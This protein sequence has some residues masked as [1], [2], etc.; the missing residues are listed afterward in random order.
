MLLVHIIFACWIH[1][2][3]NASSSCNKILDATECSD[4]DYATYVNCIRNKRLK[5]S[6]CEFSSCEATSEDEKCETCSD[7]N[8]NYC[9]SNDCQP[10]CTQC[11]AETTCD[12]AICC[13]RTCHAQC[14][15]SK[16]RRRCKESCTETIT[17]KPIILPEKVIL[18]NITTVIT[19][20]TSV[21]NT[22]VIDIPV[23]LNS[24]TTNNTTVDENSS[25]VSY[26]ET[27]DIASN[28]CNVVGPQQCKPNFRWPFLQCL[29]PTTQQCGNFC[30]SDTV[31]MQP[32][33]SCRGPSG[34]D[35]RML[36][37]PQPR[38]QCAYHYSWPYVSCGMNHQQASCE[39]CYQH[40]ASGGFP[41]QDCSPFCYDEGYGIGPYY[42]QGPFFRRAF[43]YS[44][45][46]WFFGECFSNF[47]I[48]G[49]GAP[50]GD[51]YSPNHQDWGLAPFPAYFSANCS[52]ETPNNDVNGF[53]PSN[54]NDSFVQFRPFYG[55]AYYPGG[56]PFV[57]YPKKDIKI[58]IVVNRTTAKPTVKPESRAE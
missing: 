34:C 39:G 6:D 11:C 55:Q 58:E 22:N 8:C 24:T 21:N 4:M 46:C 18:G 9:D 43:G 48:S 35:I 52:D 25:L 20:H 27:E 3:I 15:S 7:C 49:F 14:R 31:H 23:V 1:Q 17:D 30:S 41:P 53:P 32:Y 44:P 13:H 51:G 33:S 37:I 45:P 26:N 19:L 10:F 40:Y 47:G 54:S 50:I 57:E 38:P 5:R 29:H 16:C 28:C 12:T 56:Y 2:G 36:Y 42:R